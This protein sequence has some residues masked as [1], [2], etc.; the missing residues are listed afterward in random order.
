MSPGL[1]F[2]IKGDSHM[3]G[4]FSDENVGRYRK[5]ASGTLTATEWKTII[6]VLAQDRKNERRIEEASPVRC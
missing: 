1:P 6:D 2:C 4:V 3:Q 5:L